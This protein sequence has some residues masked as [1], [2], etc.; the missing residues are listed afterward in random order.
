MADTRFFPNVDFVSKTADEILAEMIESWETT[1]GRTMGKAD[2]FRVLLAWE[3]SINAQIYEAINQ[4]AKLN[5]PRYTFGEYMDSLAE[6]FYWGLERLPASAATTTLRFTLSRAATRDVAVPVGTQCS[7]D[8]TVIFATDETVYITAGETY[9]DVGATCTQTGTIGN[10]F[11]AGSITICMDPDNVTGLQSVENLTAS[12]GGAA[13]EEDEAFYERMRES[14]SAYSTA[15]PGQGYIYHAKSANSSVG[16]VRVNSPE[17]GYVDVYILKTD[18]SLPEAE[19]ISEVE[20]ALSGD[21]VRPL[22][23][24]VSVKAPETV[25]FDITV[26]W[27][28]ERG[29]TVSREQMESDL[30]AACTEFLEWQ[31]TEIGRDINPDVLAA[32][33]MGTGI[34][35]LAVTAPA[36][37]V[38]SSY[39][40]ATLNEITMTFGGDE[41]A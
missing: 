12:E 19:L 4:S 17:P 1:M 36:Y 16:S 32:K 31:T 13:E 15:G 39:Q 14:M 8:G 26:T 25:P 37:T 41:D 30:E 21:D 23:D 5:L 35:R 11:D 33:L 18:G 2:P 22:T 34:K 40:V 24:L 38:V 20:E 6:I 28:R 29:S 3:A 9:V 27:Y 7:Q 10:G